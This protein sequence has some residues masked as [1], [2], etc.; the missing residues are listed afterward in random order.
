MILMI[1]I[2]SSLPPVNHL[3]VTLSDLFFTHFTFKRTQRMVFEENKNAWNTLRIK[4]A[5]MLMDK[6]F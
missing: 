1:M 3:C 6:V 4:L 2:D 5:K